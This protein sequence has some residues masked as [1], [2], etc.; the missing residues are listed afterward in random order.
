MAPQP[1]RIDLQGFDVD[2]SYEKNQKSVR[3]SDAYNNNNITPRN[4]NQTAATID[5]DIFNQNGNF[6]NN[7]SREDKQD[8]GRDLQR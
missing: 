1:P 6:G 5:H 8:Y 4:R 7:S 3:I 2:N